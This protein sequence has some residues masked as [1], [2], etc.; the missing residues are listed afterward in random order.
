MASDPQQPQQLS[1]EEMARANAVRA[2]KLVSANLPHLAGLCHSVRVKVSRKYPVA[3]IGAS[4]LMLVNPRVFS[5]T[6]LPD[7]AFV[8]AHELMHLALDTFGRG[9]NADPHLV[10]I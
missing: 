4:G 10:N 8:I 9:G 7:L 5:E 2:L 6:Q 1:P 3:A